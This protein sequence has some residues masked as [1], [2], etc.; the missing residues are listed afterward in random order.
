MFETI[1]VLIPRLIY[2]ATGRRAVPSSSALL[3]G[4][5]LA[6]FSYQDWCQWAK[7]RLP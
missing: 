6:Y 2:A 3:F 7:W 5:T 4:H 1:P